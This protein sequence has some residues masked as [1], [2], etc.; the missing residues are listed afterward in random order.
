VFGSG[1]QKI[2]LTLFVKNVARQLA[3]LKKRQGNF[4]TVDIETVTLPQ[5]ASSLEKKSWEAKNRYLAVRPSGTLSEIEMAYREWVALDD[6]FHDTL[7]L[8][9]KTNEVFRD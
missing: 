6:S 4:M 9:K 3:E 7:R 2:V 8:I 5:L 1:L